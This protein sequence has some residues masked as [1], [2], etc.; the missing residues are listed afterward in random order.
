MMMLFHIRVTFMLVAKSSCL[1]LFEYTFTCT[2][3]HC[4]LLA[5]MHQHAVSKTIVP[6]REPYGLAGLANELNRHSELK[7]L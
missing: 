1:Q 4:L 2:F 5:Q 3:T 7:L 6:V